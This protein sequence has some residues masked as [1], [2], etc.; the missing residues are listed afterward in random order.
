M[1]IPSV[2]SALNT[3]DVQQEFLIAVLLRPNVERQA[4][5]LIHF[6]NSGNILG[7][8]DDIEVAYARLGLQQP[9][10]P[11][12]RRC[13]P[14]DLRLGGLL[15]TRTLSARKVPST[16]AKPAH[17]LECEPVSL[18]TQASS[19]WWLRTPRTIHP[20]RQVHRI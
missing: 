9:H 3:H 11:K 5:D 2:T 8:I 6:R 10:V 19:L 4:G 16:Q 12:F 1:V 13:I 20:I 15:T 18:R 14:R 17:Q 7:E